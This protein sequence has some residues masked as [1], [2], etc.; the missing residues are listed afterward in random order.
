LVNAVGNRHDQREHPRD[1]RC[2]DRGPTSTSLTVKRCSCEPEGCQAGRE[3]SINAGC[4]TPGLRR[5]HAPSAG[6]ARARG[7]GRPFA[8][9]AKPPI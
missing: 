9:G 6:R 3:D 4:G 8:G 7:R 2:P 1:P 5:G